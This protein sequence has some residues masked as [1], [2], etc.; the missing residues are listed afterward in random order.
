MVKFPKLYILE[1]FDVFIGHS[2]KDKQYAHNF[3]LCLQKIANFVPYMAEYYANP[4]EDY[5][6]RIMMQLEKSTFIIFLLT[7]NGIDSQWVNQ[8]IGYAYAL[9][10]KNKGR[11]PIVIPISSKKLEL[12][13]LITKDSDDLLF[14][15]DVIDYKWEI[16]NVILKIR[17]RV[18]K[19]FEK[20]TFKIRVTCPSCH[21]KKE[22]LPFEFEADFPSQRTLDRSILA[23]QITYTVSCPQ[24]HTK[25]PLDIRTWFP[26][27][28]PESSK[29]EIENKS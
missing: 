13:G 1:P 11:T 29:S 18:S 2:N 10:K 20:G 7:Q 17:A 26:I 5:K 8:E 21:D 9:R 14:S 27:K 23:N 25:I 6:D 4:G 19:G 12:K 16:Y 28:Q 3:F 15:D 24:C 22:N